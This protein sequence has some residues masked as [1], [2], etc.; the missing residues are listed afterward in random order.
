MK[1]IQT[2]VESVVELKTTA[3]TG[4]MLVV[5]AETVS[6]LRRKKLLAGP[7]IERMLATL[8][9]ISAATS[10]TAPETSQCVADAALS[11]RHALVE[12]SGKAN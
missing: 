7:D 12:E 9:A 1:P 10:E 5:L 4:A 6:M 11:L 3:H 8:E 2:M